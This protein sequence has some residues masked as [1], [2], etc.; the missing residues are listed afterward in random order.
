MDI[1]INSGEEAAVQLYVAYAEE[2]FPYRQDTVRSKAGQATWLYGRTEHE[3]DLLVIGL[4]L[5][6]ELTLETVRRAAGTAARAVQ[7]E[8]CASV[9]LA[10]LPQSDQALRPEESVSQEA[11]LQAWAEGWLLGL[12]RFQHHRGLTAHAALPV[13]QLESSLWPLLSTEQ[14]EAALHAARIRAE[15]TSLAR[16]LVN[17]SPHTLHPQSFAARVAEHFMRYASESPVQVRVYRGEELVERQMNGLL[18]VGAGSMHGPAMVELRYEG[19]PSLPLLALVGKGVTF[20]MGG[21]NVKTG[22]DISDARMDMGGAAAVVGALDILVRERAQAN[23]V[24]LLP[25]VDNVPDAKAVLPSSVVTYPNGMTVQI[26]NTD[27]EGRLIIADALLHAAQL[28]AAEAIDIA[29]LTG[30]VGAALGLGIAG[31][32]G[33]LPVTE[34]LIA[35]GERNGERLWQMPLMDE[36]ES[37]LA[38]SYADMRNVGSSPYAG[39]II[40]ALFIRRFVAPGMSWAHIDMAGTVQYKQDTG[41]AEAGATGYGAR[42]LADYAARR[43]GDNE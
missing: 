38:S 6:S 23:V 14:V 22:R 10:W 13:L 36:Y 39:A 41:Y 31:I 19:N 33:D 42:L 21:M 37:E 17:E 28:G 35:V 30:N 26:A 12:Y 32:W 8:G 24:A 40:A 7:R 4:G 27:G 43:L 9:R 15:G 20:D 11:W 25:I 3:A 2:A 1:R 34:Q 29:T 5:R 18:T 16:D